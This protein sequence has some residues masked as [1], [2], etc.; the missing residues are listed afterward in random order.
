M[1]NNYPIVL[2]EF[3]T[4]FVAKQNPSSKLGIP[5]SSVT[6]NTILAESSSIKIGSVPRSLDIRINTPFLVVLIVCPLFSSFITV[7]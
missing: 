6:C 7:F 5:L 2:I 3:I 1:P 4:S